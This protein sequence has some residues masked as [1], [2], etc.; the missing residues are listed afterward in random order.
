MR[1]NR[2]FTRTSHAHI[3]ALKININKNKKGKIEEGGEEEE[4]EEEEEEEGK[5]REGKTKG[6]GARGRRGWYI[7]KE[8]PQE[9]SS[10]V[11]GESIRRASQFTGMMTARTSQAVSV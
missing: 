11:E 2:K 7:K 3:H 6:E 1:L 9:R 5:G 8:D 4:K 10:T